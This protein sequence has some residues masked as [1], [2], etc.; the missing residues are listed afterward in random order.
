MVHGLEHFR[1]HPMPVIHRP[2]RMIGFKWQMRL[3]AEALLL[4]LMTA[5]TFR[6]TDNDALGRRLD[7]Q[8]AVVF[9]QVLSEKVTS[10][11]DVRN[12]RLLL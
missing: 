5:R 7:E 6:N 11:C 9:A 8:L 3:P 4:P 12:D 1:A 10:I 2:P